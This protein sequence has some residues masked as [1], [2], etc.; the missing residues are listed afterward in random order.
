MNSFKTHSSHWGAFSGRYEN[1]GLEV[2]PHP[3]D[4]HPSPL[5]GNIP[6]IAHSPMRIRRPAIRRGWLE[7][8]PGHAQNR[9]A[10]DYVE[11]SWPRAAD[12]VAKELQRV[13]GNFGP[14]AVFGGSYGWASAGRFHHA[15]S[16]IHRFLNVLG[17]YVGSV[18]T[19]SSGA[20]MVILPHV[21]GPYDHFDR[22]SVTWDAIERS[23]ELVVA[24]GGMAIKNTDVHG[25]GISAHIVPRTLNGAHAR[26]ARF[27]LVS[28]LKDDFP[29]E[30]NAEWLPI[31][32]GTDIA[33]MLGLAHVLVSEGLH[34]RQFL[35]R[36]TVGYERFEDYLLGRIDGVEKSPDWASHICGIGVDAIKTLALSMARARTLIT[37]SHSLQRADHG[38]QP[39]W[40]GI[41][42]AA[43][44]GQIGLDGGGYSYSLGA[45]GNIGKHQLA[46]PLPTLSQFKN[47]V[48]DFI[49]VARIADMLLN[50]GHE[51]NYNGHAMRYPD[52]R[53]VYWAGGNPFHHHQDLN[54]L[55][56]AFKKPE[57]IIVHETAWTS[58]ARHADI[59]LPATTTLERDD[60]GAA[61][62]DP[63][64]VAMKKLIEPV[65]EAR[66]DYE[67]FSEIARRLGKFEE[68]TENRTSREWLTFLFETTRKALVAG[69][70]E[71][72]DF[73]T[74]WERGEMR[75]PL[76][77]DD[78]GPARAFRHDPFAS[79]LQTPSGKI[80]IFSQ[81]IESFGYDDCR[82][83]PRWYPPRAEAEDDKSRFPLHLVCNQPHQRLHSQLD[84]GDFSR[85]TK[86]K[87]REPV[88]INPADAA[89]R[90]ISDGD[91]VRLFNARGSC[92]AAAVIS[93]DVR[94][95]VMQLA[96]GAWFEPDNAAS[97]KS[98]CVHGNPNIL[99]RDV[100][101][102][103]LAQGSTGQLTRVDAERFVGELPPVRIFEGM[104]FFDEAE[105]SSTRAGNQ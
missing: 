45:L 67:I 74:F 9:G 94:K 95:S 50:P 73:E 69:G 4:P 84:Y 21:L 88:R 36:Y 80:E 102:S 63:L 42:L 33:L 97:D 92:L 26:G 32:P 59:V 55:R 39:V 65:G 66:D 30:V 19:Y 1:G 53:L 29:P 57:T 71:A 41:V 82:G 35:D 2:R 7:G 77:P 98:M 79:P 10:D 40:M 61:D 85:S 87:G 31:L 17:G 22:K 99:T 11:V 43:M 91:I 12:F 52:I 14:E 76:K 81:R 44:L 105:R 103:Q 100:G 34:D 64:M 90:G 56:A 20:A 27:V 101:T 104:T 58:S 51:Y 75:L 24:F 23:S 78:G 37:V 89:E 3:G 54:R 5:L 13:Y 6:A 93:E 38:E 68:F 47:A 49:P 18:N 48:S 28:P 70:H 60:I 25:G 83:H 86:I 46:V 16:Q 15:Q 62:R 8:A 72:P 96:T